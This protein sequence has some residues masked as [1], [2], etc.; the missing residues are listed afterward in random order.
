MAHQQ[1]QPWPRIEPD[2]L[3]T[4]FEASNSDDTA[5]LEHLIEMPDLTLDEVALSIALVELSFEAVAKLLQ[6]RVS[7]HSA[8]QLTRPR[9]ST[10]FTHSHMI[11][12]GS[13]KKPQV[14]PSI[15]R[16]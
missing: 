16:R 2:L 10:L 8:S 13:N 14:I 3:S 4:L 7:G 11:F 6:Q 5:P 1:P 15:S 12:H 9:K